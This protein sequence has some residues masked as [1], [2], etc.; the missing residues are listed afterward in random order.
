MEPMFC[1]DC[2]RK[3]GGVFAYD[4]HADRKHDRCRTDDE[5]KVRGL[6]RDKHHV[7]HRKSPVGQTSTL[8]GILRGSPQRRVDGAPVSEYPP[9]LTTQENAPS[10][11]GGSSVGRGA[12]TTSPKAHAPARAN[13]HPVQIQDPLGPTPRG[14][15]GADGA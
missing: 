3:F 6:H 11:V 5:L 10:P 15:V 4:R 13:A 12:S 14:G 9:T 8:P 2:R 1:P 7:W